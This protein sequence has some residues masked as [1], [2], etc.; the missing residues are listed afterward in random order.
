M[1]IIDKLVSEVGVIL[2]SSPVKKSMVIPYFL[3]I[4]FSLYLIFDLAFLIS[5]SRYIDNSTIEKVLP[6]K[7]CFTII[8]VIMIVLREKFEAS[9]FGQNIVPY[10]FTLFYLFSLM[11]LGYVVGHLSIVTGVVIAATPLLCMILFEARI[12]LVLICVGVISFQFIAILYVMGIAPY[13]PLFIESIKPDIHEKMFYLVCMI[14]FMLPF[15]IFF[16]F[17]TYLLVMYWRSREDGIRRVSF[18][19]SLTEMSNRRAI[20]DYLIHAAV[21]REDSEPLSIVLVD[22]DHFKQVND[23]FGH[24]MGDLVLRRVGDSIKISLRGYDQVGR[25]GGEEFLIVLANTSLESARQIAE[26][27]RIH[28]ENEVILDPEENPIRVTASFGIY[29]SITL[30]EDVA[31]MIHYA[32]IELYR[33]KE[34]GRNRVCAHNNPI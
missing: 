31:Q 26:R 27:C 5:P 28:I 33:A 11:T 20:S 3:L 22:I 15:L 12:T 6:I 18:I 30:G 17:G 34:E 14:F 8:A 32:D 24:L 25:Y 10:V 19:D 7:A 1:K 23:T 4:V 16:M 13:A 9:K 2:E 21:N 29:C